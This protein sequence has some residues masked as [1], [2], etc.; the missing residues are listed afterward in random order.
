MTA[1][2]YLIGAQYAT[3]TATA[4]V[5]SLPPIGAPAQ[6]T[7]NPTT[8]IG[9]KDLGDVGPL[10]ADAFAQS[11]YTTVSSESLTE[12]LLTAASNLIVRSKSLDPDFSAV[13]DQEFWNLLQ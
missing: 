12:L 5:L 11:I 13:V 9:Y 6:S 8:K 10:V 7:I 2:R 4:L 3:A 1:T